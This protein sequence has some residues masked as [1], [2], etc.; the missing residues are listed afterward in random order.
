MEREP[1]PLMEKI[2]ESMGLTEEELDVLEGLRCIRVSDGLDEPWPVED[3]GPLATGHEVFKTRRRYYAELSNA[4]FNQLCI[5]PTEVL[6]E[7]FYAMQDVSRETGYITTPA[8][9]T[10]T[11][12]CGYWRQLAI[13]TPDLWNVF[14]YSALRSKQRPLDRLEVYL[15][16]SKDQP[17]DLWLDLC[18]IDTV[19][20][21]SNTSD[22][23]RL[24]KQHSDRWRVFHVVSDE[25]TLFGNFHEELENVSAP[26]LEILGLCPDAS[27]HDQWG[28]LVLNVAT[29]TPNVL[30]QSQA[31]KYVR[32]DTGSFYDLRPPLTSVVELRIENRYYDGFRT[33][34][35][36]TEFIDSLFRLPNLEVLSVFNMDLVIPDEAL[37]VTRPR[38][39]AKRLQH[40]RCTWDLTNNLGSY[41]LLH[42][43]APCLESYTITDLYLG[44]EN[45]HFPFSRSETDEDPFPSLQ[46]VAFLGASVDAGSVDHLL[47]MMT[48]MKNVK[49]FVL[50]TA[51]N[52]QPNERQFPLYLAAHG[53]EAGAWPGLEKL[54]F[55]ADHPTLHDAL[56]PLVKGFPKL[57]KLSVPQKTFDSVRP[58]VRE[59]LPRAIELGALEDTDPLIPLYWYPCGEWLDSEFDPFLMK[60]EDVYEE[61][62]GPLRSDI[63]PMV[64]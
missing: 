24:L 41:F 4:C 37:P 47:E 22:I 23:W 62:C 14:Q 6:L 17:F 34:V 2:A 32:L 11:H 63:V 43:D 45:Q 44:I 33:A 60:I 31:L 16:R 36:T 39:E 50:S 59:R 25:N 42:A 19:P 48:T 18:D 3:T 57:N 13:S 28:P 5:F 52:S 56:E 46:T 27:P 40:F 30:L 15:K 26:N 58:E 38:I 1:R 10:I 8:E 35:L 20:G 21:R 51:A 29:W 49:H 55:N 7:L 9:T 61:V 12:V 53:V 54:T 64:T